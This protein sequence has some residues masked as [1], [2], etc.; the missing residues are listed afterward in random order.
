MSKYWKAIIAAGGMVLV[1]L[2]AVAGQSAGLSPQAQGYVTLG[3][4]ILTPVLVW[5]KANEP[6]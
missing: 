3:I 6:A 4:A 5:A 1:V 2:N